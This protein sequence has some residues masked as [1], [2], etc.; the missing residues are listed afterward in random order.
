L[1]MWAAKDSNGLL[2]AATSLP[3]EYQNIAV[4]TALGQ[5]SRRSPDEAIRIARRLDARELRTE[6]RDEIVRQ[7][8]SV[9]AKAAFE[10]M[11][12]DGLGVSD[13]SDSSILHQVFSAYLSQ[14]FDSAQRFV[15]E[16]EGEVKTQLVEVVARR[17][18]HSDLDRGIDYLSNVTDE[19]TR[20]ELQ[21][22]IGQQL[23]EVDPF[24]ALRYGEEVEKSHRDSYYSGVVWE[25]A[26]NDFFA[27]HKNINRVPADARTYAADALLHNN[28]DNN[29]LNEREVR[30]LESMIASERMVTISSE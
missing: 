28:E 2:N 8:S 11:I 17:L 26:Y 24:E 4:V 1:R 30:K 6:A 19:T 13:E 7:W 10:W 3:R 27:L 29:Y 23:V 25:W 16:Y 5:L 9:N 12:R 21:F 15:G 22:E 14:D 20:G 18:I